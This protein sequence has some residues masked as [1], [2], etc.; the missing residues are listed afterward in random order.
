MFKTVDEVFL[1][2]GDD[3]VVNVKC[4]ARVIHIVSH[5]LEMNFV[6]LATKMLNTGLKIKEH[7]LNFVV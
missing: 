3:V 1:S 5:R 4:P 2:D 6:E 7:L